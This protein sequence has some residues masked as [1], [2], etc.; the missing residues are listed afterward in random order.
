MSHGVDTVEYRM[1]LPGFEGVSKGSV[2]ITQGT[3]LSD[4]DNPVLLLRQPRQLVVT[5]PF[6]VHVEH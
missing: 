2:R 3:Q 1:Q 4:R 5:S 6:W